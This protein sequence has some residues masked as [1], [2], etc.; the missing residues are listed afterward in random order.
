[1]LFKYRFVR[2]LG[3]SKTTYSVCTPTIDLSLNCDFGGQEGEFS[4]SRLRL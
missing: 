3:D 1:M 2:I 4:Y